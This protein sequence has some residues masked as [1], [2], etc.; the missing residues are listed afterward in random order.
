MKNCK[1]VGKVLNPQAAWHWGVTRT[2]G[3]GTPFLSFSKAFRI[4]LGI[5]RLQ[6]CSENRI[7]LLK[8]KDLSLEENFFSSRDRFAFLLTWIGRKRG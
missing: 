5:R 1:I 6:V 2:K 3:C 4:L 8:K 7:S